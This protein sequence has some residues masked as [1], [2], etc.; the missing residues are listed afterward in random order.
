MTDKKSVPTA[1]RDEI[2]TIPRDP[3]NPAARLK[4]LLNLDDTLITRGGSRGLRIYDEL[5]RDG[6]TMSCLRK[7]KMA[8]LAYPWQLEAA[9]DAPLDQ[10][11]AALVQTQF[12]SMNFRETCL[13][14]QDAILKGFSVGEV[15]WG[16]DQNGFIAPTMVIARD[17]RRFVFGQDRRL[18]MRD[19][20][21]MWDG[22]E[23]P[24]R[25]FI[26]HSVGSK[27]GSPYGL[28]L[29]YVLFWYVFFKR[30]DITF[31]LTFLDKFG[32]PTALGTFRSGTNPDDQEKLLWAT[33]AI[34]QDAGIVIPDTC[35]IDLLEAQRSGSVD[36]YERAARYFDEEITI[37]VLGETLTTS[38][39][40]VGSQAATTV[41]D[42]V[43]LELVQ[44]DGELLAA[45]L[46]T[47]LVRWVTEMN[48]AGANPPI[49]KFIVGQEE[50]LTARAGR[51]KIISDM[52]F[53]PTLNYITE[54]YGGEWTE[55]AAM[56]PIGADPADTPDE[57]TPA[58]AEPTAEDDLVA[59]YAER[60]GSQADPAIE[61][62]I[63]TI[64]QLVKDGSSLEG[65]R[66]KLL[67]LYDG[68]DPAAFAEARAAGLGAA[69]G[70]GALSAKKARRR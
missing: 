37:T 18:R 33:F 39:A 51:D 5:E 11:A 47:T 66:D 63:G 70:A 23:L 21:N 35:K 12:K 56:P 15:L 45:S 50:N 58:F 7:R 46:N 67:D 52:G 69:A 59:R 34:A 65:I 44:S 60:L 16:I 64:H 3:W 10:A 17:Q 4:W 9:S 14:L 38:N 48:L 2:A 24:D 62:M 53:K 8:L 25:K 36:A 43:R 31:W 55:R 49:L 61:A 54:T 22:V 40:G 27:D 30:Q 6:R 42:D 13:A 41:H 68:L 28:G 32:S 19:W 57:N 20:S 26:V 29:G 1:I